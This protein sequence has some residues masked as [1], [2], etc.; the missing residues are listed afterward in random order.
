MSASNQGIKAANA[1]IKNIFS[2]LPLGSDFLILPL[3]PL[4]VCAEVLTAWGST[5]L[6]NGRSSTPGTSVQ[7]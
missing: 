4:T 7:G 1:S 2:L 3:Y 5:C 6:V